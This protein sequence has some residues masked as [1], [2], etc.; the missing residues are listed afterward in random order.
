M[1]V[2]SKNEK[3]ISKTFDT[4][5]LLSLKRNA[6]RTS[7]SYNQINSDQHE[8]LITTILYDRLNNNNLI[9][10]NIVAIKIQ[11]TNSNKTDNNTNKLVK[12][13]K[14]V[15]YVTLSITTI[16]LIGIYNLQLK[17]VYLPSLNDGLSQIDTPSQ[18]GMPYEE[19]FLKTSD[20]VMLQ[21]YVLRQRLNKAY[22][23]RNKNKSYKNTT[24]VILCPNAGNIGHSLPIVQIF[25][26]S[27]HYN[28][29]IY[30]YRGYG[31][32][33]GSPNESGLKI[34]A[35]T[36]LT[37]LS[38]DPEF[39]KSKIILY[40]RSIGGAVAIYMASLASITLSRNLLQIENGPQETKSVLENTF[41][42]IRKVIPYI[43]PILSYL[44]FLC[45]QV[46]P[47]E[48]Y[49]TL[50]DPNI[51]TLFLSGQKDEIVPPDHMFQLYK[52]SNS[53]TKEIHLF[54]DGYHNDTVNQRFY[55]KYVHN[56]IEAISI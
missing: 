53:K 30:S 50:I 14:I 31:R 24:I 54:K 1:G 35:Q 51:P 55:W 39:K 27:F 9:K 3:R 2:L 41:L 7:R 48:R 18:Y 19:I 37:F 17:L 43:F 4:K 15:K 21:V 13:G 5:H 56:F 16:G 25:Y 23:N 20:M 26:K 45:H 40:G 22:K 6:S 8:R 46:W 47:S 44:S 49:I 11:T 38:Q 36:I 29:V 33:T 52:L 42:N 32:S 34:D 12:I 10:N 28:V